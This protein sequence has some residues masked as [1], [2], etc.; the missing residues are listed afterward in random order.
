MGKWDH[1][2]RGRFYRREK[3]YKSPPPSYHEPER[4]LSEYCND[5]VPLWE[6]KFCT[7]VGLVSWRKIL[8]VQRSIKWNFTSNVL[9]WEDSAG[10]EAF[11]NAKKRYWSKINGLPC[12]ISLPDPNIYIDEIDWYPD[13]D[14]ELI[15]DLEQELAASIP[16][17]GCNDNP[18]KV[19]NPWECG[20]DIQHGESLK[21]N[22]GWGHW[23]SRIEDSKNLNGND[24]LWKCNSNQ[25]NEASQQDLWG[26]HGDKSQDFSQWGKRKTLSRDCDTNDNPWEHSCSGIGSIGDKGWGQLNYNSWNQNQKE[27][28]K[29]DN[30]DNPWGCSI[31]QDNGARGNQQWANYRRNS[32]GWKQRDNYNNTRR[33]LGVRKSNGDWEAR[34]VGSRKREGSDR[35]MNDYKSSRLQRDDSQT[36]HFWRSGKANKRVSFARN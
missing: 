20:N 9:Q 18:C 17:D 6:K 7:L 16:P 33:E 25:R 34:T 30:G 5:G 19:D 27:S 21:D 35:Y 1:R 2:P 14:P 11:E 15:K 8:D 4:S 31:V 23:N 12:D 29:L 22:Q 10:K 36:D 3:A 28:K 24:D 32:R 26:N 13:I